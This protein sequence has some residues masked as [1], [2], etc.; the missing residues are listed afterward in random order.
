MQVQYNQIIE[1]EMKVSI[2]NPKTPGIIIKT[3]TMDQ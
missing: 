2:K 3:P 1:C